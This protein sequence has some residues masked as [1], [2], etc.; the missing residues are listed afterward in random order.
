MGSF[1]RDHEVTREVFESAFAGPDEQRLMDK[2]EI[3]ETDRHDL[4]EVLDSDNSGVLTVDELIKGIMAVR[5]QAKKSDMVATR[6]AV[7]AVQQS[8]RNIQVDMKQDR[9]SV[10]AALHSVEMRLG[11]LEQDLATS[12]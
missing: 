4:F 9:S 10:E 1:D 3:D 5:G 12:Y 8:L 6:L 2:L 7:M 11:M